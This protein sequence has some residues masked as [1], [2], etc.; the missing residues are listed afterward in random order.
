[1][2]PLSQAI[3]G[4]DR[5]A[6]PTELRQAQAVMF[7]ILLEIKRIC[8]KHAIRFWL[9]GGTLLGAARHG[10]FIPWDDDV[11]IVMPRPDYRRFLDVAA[12]ELPSGMRVQT[13][14]R[15]ECYRRYATP[16]KVRDA[17]SRILEPGTPAGTQ[18]GLFVDIIP[19]DKFHASGVRHHVDYA[20]KW[21]YKRLC[22]LHHGKRREG[23]GL[24]VRLNNLVV[25]LRPH[26]PTEAT[27]RRYRNWL[28]RHVVARNE[29]LERDYLVGYGF[30]SYWIRLFPPEDIFPLA[31][32]DFEGIGFPVPHDC[33]RVLRVFY[34]AG[35]RTVPPEGERPPAHWTLIDIDTRQPSDTQPPPG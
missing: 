29:R 19:L 35:W 14:E 33:D 9:D 30:D 11:D 32:L 5:T 18:G 6:H 25:S 23:T 12:M 34:G 17:Y 21:L 22:G 27:L 28:Q 2:V 15:D 1:M 16:C 26:L 20:F 10:G 3:P 8:E 31:S 7:G 24:R 4:T 13:V